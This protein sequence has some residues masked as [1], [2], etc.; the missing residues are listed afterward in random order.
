MDLSPR[1]PTQK[2][3]PCSD[4]GPRAREPGHRAMLPIVQGSRS[5]A[6]SLKKKQCLGSLLPTTRNGLSF[7][8]GQMSF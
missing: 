3:P 6:P 2:L 1:S 5:G 7:V 8:G 4:K